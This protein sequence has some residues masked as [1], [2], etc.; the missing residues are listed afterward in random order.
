MWVLSIKRNVHGRW[1][2][3]QKSEKII[4]RHV[5]HATCCI[6]NATFLTTEGHFKTGAQMI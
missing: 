2:K 5:I 3:K 1:M 4:N 6:K